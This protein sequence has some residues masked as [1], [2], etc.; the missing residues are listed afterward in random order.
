MIRVGVFGAAGGWAPRCARPS[1][2][3]PTSSWSPP[4]TRPRR[5]R[6]APGH[7]RRR[8]GHLQIAP[9]RRR[10]RTPGPTWP[11]TSPTSAAARENLRWC[12]ENGVHAVVGTTGF[13]RRRPRRAS[14]TP[15]DQPSNCLI[16]PNFA[17]GAVLMMR[18][19]ELAAPWFETAEIIELHH[20]QKVDAPVGH[21]HAHGRA[22]GRRR[23]RTGRPTR[24][25]RGRA[26]RRPRR[27]GAG[28]AS[29]S[30]RCA[31][32]AWSPTRRCCSAPPARPSRSATT[33][34]TARRSCPASC[35]P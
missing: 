5:A 11:S 26:R 28:A 4:S 23:R 3:T 6:P 17:I 16:A 14:R 34:T 1:P 31:C 8:V 24:P 10:S 13:E 21:G 30:T 15:F 29:A 2:A 19:A 35:W 22:H 27:R 18:F 32:G 20:D 33:P 9:D 12:A 7:R 25:R